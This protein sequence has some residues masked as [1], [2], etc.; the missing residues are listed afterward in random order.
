MVATLGHLAIKGKLLTLGM[1]VFPLFLLL[2]AAVR[3]LP[4][5]ILALI[6]VGWGFMILFNMANTLVQTLVPDA[7][8]GRVVS[9][10]TL[11][12]F[13]LMP[14]GALLAG[15]VAQLFNEPVTIILSG[16]ISL[17]FAVWLWLAAPQLRALP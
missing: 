4:L 6:G 5:S 13:G 14:L 7:L 3:Q 12:F 16:L 17:G 2:F 1:F 11:G 10:Y 15:G 8:R 9:I